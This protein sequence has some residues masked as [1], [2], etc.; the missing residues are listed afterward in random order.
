MSIDSI[1]AT[2]TSQTYASTASG[3]TSRKDENAATGSSAAGNPQDT[4]TLSHEARRFAVDLSNSVN[5]SDRAV[6]GKYTG[7]FGSNVTS[8]ASDEYA[9]YGEKMTHQMRTGSQYGKEKLAYL[10]QKRETMQKIMENLNQQSGGLL[11]GAG[12][13]DDLSKPITTTSGAIHPDAE[14][15]RSFLRE[16]QNELS[17]LKSLHEQNFP[18]FDEWQASPRGEE[19]HTPSA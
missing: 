16:H 9:S 7:R 14:K 12:F 3:A 5:V 18:S 11:Y 2:T 15:I 8:S 6:Y 19:Q 13:S 10:N 4:I 17:Q 1:N